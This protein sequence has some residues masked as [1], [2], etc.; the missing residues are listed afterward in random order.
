[1][2]KV[3]FDFKGERYVVTGA[4]SGIG[5]QVAIELAEAGADVLA[6]GRNGKRL[7]EVQ[8]HAPEHMF[9]AVCDVC[10]AAALE[11]AITSFVAVHGKVNGGV[12]AAGITEFTPLQSY[13]AELAHRIMETSFWAG[14]EVL[15]L[16]TKSKYGIRGTSTVLFSSVSAKA[17]V[18]GKI[19]YVAAKEAINA[20]IRAAAKEI[21]RRGH[22]VNSVLPGW[23]KTPMTDVAEEDGTN[24]ALIKDRSLLGF[25]TPEDVSGMV[26]FLLS[27]RARWMT[28][29]CIPVDGGYLA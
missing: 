24:M 20:A 14:M 13:D 29:A 4:S 21:C 25:G 8:H 6:I 22:R 9:P 19:A 18:G 11:A 7:A 12:H 23:V 2:S 3:T 5:R 15:R 26:L 27:N 16:V 17:P 1:M 10:D 28:G